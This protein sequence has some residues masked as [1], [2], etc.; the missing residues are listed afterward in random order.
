M[1]MKKDTLLTVNKH[2]KDA[3]A[4]YLDKENANVYWPGGSLGEDSFAFDALTNYFGNGNRNA[5]LTNA[6]REAVSYIPILGEGAPGAV[7]NPFY[8]KGISGAVSGTKTPWL[9]TQAGQAAAGAAANIAASIASPFVN[10]TLSKGYSSGAGN[11]ISGMAPVVGAVASMIPGAG[12]LAGPIATLAT[13]AIGGLT[14]HAFGDKKNEEKIAAIKGNTSDMYNMGNLAAKSYT[15]DTLKD[16]I[17]NMKNPVEYAKGSVWKKGFL[18][19]NRYGNENKLYALQ[20]AADIAQEHGIDIGM[21]NI[22]KVI[23]SQAYLDS[24]AYGGPL[25]MNNIDPLTATGYGLIQSKNIND[26]NKVQS[27]D[28][29]LSSPFAGVPGTLFDGNTLAS[30]G[31]IH[32]KK[33]NKGK[34]TEQAKRA[35]M[36]VQ[37]FAKH[38]LANKGKYSSDTVKRANFAR[39]AAKWHAYGGLL[40]DGNLFAL[41]GYEADVEM[42]DEE[43]ADNMMQ[44]ESLGSTIQEVPI[45]SGGQE[46]AI[47]QEA[48]QEEEQEVPAEEPQENA[49]ESYQ[50]E[51][52]DEESESLEV[53]DVID[54]SEEEAARLKAAGYEFN[55]VGQ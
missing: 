17:R 31:K 6:A 21:D 42:P 13:S 10:K 47:P 55:I 5:A 39:N 14:N 15:T 32:I 50:E 43:V 37:Q 48:I 12:V 1:Y 30:G 3:F 11:V 24:F 9:K 34:F 26:M 35:G 38:V 49:Q 19:K 33:K 52:A 27:Q 45:Q 29:A 25:M 41:G 54:V 8:Y 46:Q 28:N 20:N 51:N 4:R 22:N 40:D 36:S 16:A 53:G 23:G 44:Q 2:N 18:G 7:P